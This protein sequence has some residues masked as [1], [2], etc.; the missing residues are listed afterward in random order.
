M[1]VL[2]MSCEAHVLSSYLYWADIPSISYASIYYIPMFYQVANSQSIMQSNSK[3]SSLRR[4]E[5]HFELGA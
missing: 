4:L 3:L 1:L 2:A 5:K